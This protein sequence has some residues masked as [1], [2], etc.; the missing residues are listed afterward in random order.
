MIA[1]DQAE[2]ALTAELAAVSSW[3]VARGTLK[4]Y[5]AIG[6][7]AVSR[8]RTPL[9][10]SSEIGA[11]RLQPICAWTVSMRQLMRSIGQPEIPRLRVINV[12]LKFL[13]SESPLSSF[14]T[15][16]KGVVYEESLADSEG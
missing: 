11:N 8:S 13:A 2:A 6:K 14:P 15:S 1:R 7:W 9:L 3:R 4:E 10:T 12:D 16:H 5:Q